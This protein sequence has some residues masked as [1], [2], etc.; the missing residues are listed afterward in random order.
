ME[1][2]AQLV[3][4][5]AGRAGRAEHPGVAIMQTHNGDHPRLLSLIEQGYTDFARQELLERR[6][7]AMPPFSHLAM[8]RAEA[9]AGGRAEAL[10]QLVRDMVEQH[11]WPG[12]TWLGPLP[13]PMERRAGRYR[14]QLLFESG[15]RKALHRLLQWLTRALE[16][17]PQARKVRWTLDVDPLDMH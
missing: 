12:V 17:L 11:D 6:Q 7:G 15:E 4:Q 9:V 16:G 14:A 1:K 8:L 2:T 13:S 3:L 5:V 10:L